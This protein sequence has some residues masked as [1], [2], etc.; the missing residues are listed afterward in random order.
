MRF[1]EIRDMVMTQSGNDPSDS[2]EYEPALS[3]YINEGYGN[4]LYEYSHERISTAQG[5]QYPYL[6]NEMDVPILPEYLHRPIADYATYLIYRNGNIS[7]QQRGN[8]FYAQYMKALG[9]ARSDSM[10]G[11]KFTHLYD[12]QV[13]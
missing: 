5:A 12:E 10:R 6:K 1:G 4:L 2:S 9:D 7:K 13:Y 8:S 3:Q 11:M